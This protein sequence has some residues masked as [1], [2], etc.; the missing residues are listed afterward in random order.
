MHIA[1]MV[2]RSVDQLFMD[3]DNSDANPKP[4]QVRRRRMVSV[5]FSYVI[6]S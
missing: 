6:F 2:N 5:V 3:M 1:Y 4:S